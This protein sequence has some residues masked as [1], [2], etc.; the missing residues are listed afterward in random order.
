M[1][2]KKHILLEHYAEGSRKK[3]G[4]PQSKPDAE[5]GATIPLVVKLL[6]ITVYALCVLWFFFDG[7]EWETVA[8][9]EFTPDSIAA[10]TVG[11]VLWVGL[12]V[13]FVR[14]LMR[15]DNRGAYLR[16]HLGIPL[17]LVAVVFTYFVWL[18]AVA[19]AL[20]VGG[21]ILELPH[22]TRDHEL[23]TALALIVFV[24]LI[25]TIG[26]VRVESTEQD[27]KLSSISN[28]LSW[29]IARLLEAEYVP[30]GHDVENM[31]EVQPLTPDGRDLAAVLAVC[32]VLF[33]AL[34]VG[35]VVSW[36]TRRAN[37]DDADTSETIE[38]LAGEVAGLRETLDRIAAK[39]ELDARDETPDRR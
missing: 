1:G 27:S 31:I 11:A 5:P 39:L 14:G 33:A 37:E 9:M 13:Y 20:I 23:T 29:T 30:F 8:D 18:P 4:A 21:F 16:A 7:R 17:L 36:L 38:A 32:G 15:A 24:S 6:I 19:L 22:H 28:G 3:A 2:R 10:A 34:I 26:L 25:V 35:A 12:A